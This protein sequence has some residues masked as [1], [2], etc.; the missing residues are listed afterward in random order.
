MLGR[1]WWRQSSQLESL[2]ASVYTCQRCEVASERAGRIA[3]K[4]RRSLQ[5]KARFHLGCRCH[6][7]CVLRWK[8]WRSRRGEARSSE[9]LVKIAYATWW[10]SSNRR[11]ALSAQTMIHRCSIPLASSWP[12]DSSLARPHQYWYTMLSTPKL[13]RWLVSTPLLALRR[14]RK[15]MSSVG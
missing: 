15:R 4:L 1:A 7:G 14:W 13:P 10:N 12:W 9:R 8:L 2:P 5:S 11:P 6:L 3:L